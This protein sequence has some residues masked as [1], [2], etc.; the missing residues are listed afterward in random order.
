MF[1]SRQS[2]LSLLQDLY[3]SESFQLVIVYGRRRVGKST[4]LREFCKGKTHVSFF[5]AR[6]TTS[7]ENLR[8]LSAA[9]LAKEEDTSDTSTAP[10]YQDFDGAIGAAFARARSTRDHVAAVPADGGGSLRTRAQHTQHIGH[11]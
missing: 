9:L 5:T 3:E 7:A 1:V 6:E 11:R 2:E 10:I 4:L 8:R